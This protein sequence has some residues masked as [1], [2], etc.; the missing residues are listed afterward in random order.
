MGVLPEPVQMT[1]QPV[2]SPSRIINYPKETK[3]G[4]T[5][6]IEWKPGT[7]VVR[8]ST[9]LEFGRRVAR[10]V[11]VECIV[12]TTCLD[13]EIVA[14]GNKFRCGLGFENAG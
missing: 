5:R 8:R 1:V 14:E 11:R 10:N 7:N 3:S 9:V 2:K 13:E 12:Y 6:I 4:A